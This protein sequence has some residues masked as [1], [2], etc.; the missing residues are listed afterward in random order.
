MSDFFAS[1][2]RLL[3]GK[4][5]KA[6]FARLLGIPP[7]MYHRYEGGQ[8]PKSGNLQVIAAKCNTTVDWL[9]GGAAKGMKPTGAAQLEAVTLAEPVQDGALPGGATSNTQI[10]EW[11]EKARRWDALC[12][13]LGVAPD[14]KCAKGK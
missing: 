6:E 13:L 9:L 5:S 10:L 3:R 2:L 7:P 11:R 1:R 12:E 8:V 4:Q 14:T